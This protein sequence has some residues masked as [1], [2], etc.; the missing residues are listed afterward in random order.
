MD[1]D[2][3]IFII[4][5]ALA[6]AGC[7]G[8]NGARG[9]SNGARIEATYR[10]RFINN[11]TQANFPIQFPVNAHLTGMVGATHSEDIKF[12]DVGT[13]ASIGVKDVAETGKKDLM[14]NEV[15][16][17][18]SRGFADKALSGNGVNFGMTETTMEFS[19]RS[20]HPR[21]TLISMLGPSPDWFTGVQGL[22]LY[23]DNSWVSNLDIPLKV[24]DSG[25]DDGRTFNSSNSASAPAKEV[26]LLNTADVDSDF[27]NGVKRLTGEYVARMIFEKL[28]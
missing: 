6:L 19:I 13:M 2:K 7:G 28:S 17:E 16:R 12:F 5:S 18:I 24:Y 10:V 15:G 22:L 1:L 25:T 21:V 23:V 14:L 9:G 4:S 3:R 27:T 8:S 20:S 11:W 26:Q